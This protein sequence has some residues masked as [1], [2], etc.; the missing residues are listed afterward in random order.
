MSGEMGNGISTPT[1][2]VRRPRRA[3]AV[4]V[5]GLVLLVTPGLSGCHD[6]CRLSN[7]QSCPDGGG[8]DPPKDKSNERRPAERP[9][10]YHP[11]PVYHP[12]LR[13]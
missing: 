1:H 2:A 4:S 10:E 11:P 8:G 13:G 3:V 6:D 5:I 12:P 7:G 9:P